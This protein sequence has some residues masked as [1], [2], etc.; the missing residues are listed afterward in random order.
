M[1]DQPFRRRI[2]H[3]I[4]RYDNH[5][6]LSGNDIP[7]KH[8]LGEADAVLAEMKPELDRLADY[9]AGAAAAPVPPSAGTDLRAQLLDALDFAYCQGLGYDSPEA[10]LA[11]YDAARGVP[12]PPPA[13]QTAL[14]AAVAEVL[15]PLTDWDG[16]QLNAE[17]AADAVMAVLPEQTDRAAVPLTAVERQF[18][19]FALDLAFDRMVSDDGF[20]SEDEA[21]LETLRQMA[22][23]EQPAETPM[24]GS[25]ACTCIPFTRQTDPPRILN[26]PTDT[27]DMISG[28]EIGRDCP[29]HKPA[30]GE[31]P[32]TQEAL[33]PLVD[34]LRRALAEVS[35]FSL[36]GLEPHDYQAHAAAVRR[37]V[38]RYIRADVELD[39]DGLDDDCCRNYGRS[40]ARWLEADLLDAEPQP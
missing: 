5:H 36:E 12:V 10:L 35:G 16:D 25:I 14:R 20:T 33:P 21:A 40:L 24:F 3:A 4:H 34:E 19:T 18:L 26:R 30:V 28:W 27:V 31:Q 11:A 15:W 39:V 1:T 6:A 37:V 8:H 17:A 29:H 32:E 23:E 38:A 7:S 13:D 9:D 22:A 2:A